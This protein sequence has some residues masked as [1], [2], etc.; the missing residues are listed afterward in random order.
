[1]TLADR[2]LAPHTAE[3][4][5]GLARPSRRRTR[6][7]PDPRRERHDEV[8]CSEGKTDQAGRGGKLRFH[9]DGILKR[10]RSTR[11][12]TCRLELWLS[13]KT[14]ESAGWDLLPDQVW[15]LGVR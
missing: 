5:L 4:K 12:T 1:M 2:D 13:Q 14:A 6:P 10:V 15:M 11:S 8:H 9:A 3:A 7:P